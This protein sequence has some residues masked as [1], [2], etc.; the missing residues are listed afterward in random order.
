MTTTQEASFDT[1]LETEPEEPQRPEPTFDLAKDTISSF[2]EL[3]DLRAQV[4]ARRKT[5]ER[6]RNQV[7][8]LGDDGDAG[9]RRGLGLWLLGDYEQAAAVLA[10]HESDDV[11]SFTRATALLSLR[12]PAEALPIFE[13]LSTAYP[14]VARPRCGVLEA[15]LEADLEKGDA[16]AAAERLVADL[17]K[18]DSAF[19]ESC[20]GHYIQARAAELQ[21]DWQ[22]AVDHYIAARDVDGA[23]RANLFRGAHLAERCGLDEIAVD[24]Y[25]DLVKLLPIDRRTMMNLGMLYE[26]L[27][28]DQDAAACYDT[29]VKSYPTDRRARLYFEDARS[30][31]DMYYDEEL[32]RKED[33][34]NQILRTPITDFELSVRARNCLNKMNILTLGDLVRLTEQELLSYKNFGET[35][36]NEIKEIL[37]SKGLRLG[38]A[39]EEAVASIEAHA[40]PRATGENADLLNKAIVELELSIRAR[41]TV[42]NVG[43]L[44]VGDI[45]QHTEEEL[46]GMPNFG[47]TSLQELKRKLADIGLKLPRKKDKEG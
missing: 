46:L 17:E 20:E 39:H 18:A 37:G 32:E 13:R 47:Q 1:P 5:V 41:R 24:M 34:L 33:R 27:G 45:M 10:S 19:L 40:R 12:R 23:N 7:Q 28:R 8:A 22:K 36:L 29:V 38:M 26:D 4:F 31:M 25:E 9:R 43:C 2:S 14:D 6:Y 16:D 44:T 3:E 15:R 35:S 30:A 11:A 42:E 21:R